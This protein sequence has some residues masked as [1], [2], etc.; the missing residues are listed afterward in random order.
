GHVQ[1]GVRRRREEV[2]VAE[3]RGVV[4]L[5]SLAVHAMAHGAHSAIELMAVAL[6][7]REIAPAALERAAADR[8]EHGK[9]AHQE[10]ATRAARWGGL[11]D[12]GGKH[13]R[14]GSV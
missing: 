9:G 2:R 7:G 11:H 8:R 12:G 14:K 6:D 1:K 10:L 5:V 13:S 3:P 4:G